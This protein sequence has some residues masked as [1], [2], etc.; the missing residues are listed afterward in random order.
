MTL[1]RQSDKNLIT[2][3][4]YI[5]YIIKKLSKTENDSLII[6]DYS[7]HIFDNLTWYIQGFN[8]LGVLYLIAVL[9]IRI[10]AIL[11]E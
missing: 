2:L 7:Y 6:S 9:K 3:P 8:R 1:Y 11:Q 5:I 10:F 4:K